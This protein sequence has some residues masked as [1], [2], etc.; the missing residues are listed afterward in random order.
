MDEAGDSSFIV[1]LP[2]IVTIL[3][4]IAGS[5]ILPARG[6]GAVLFLFPSTLY[7]SRS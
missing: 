4:G 7:C 5:P 3:L 1:R 6:S 2:A